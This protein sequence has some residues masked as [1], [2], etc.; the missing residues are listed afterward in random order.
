MTSIFIPN[1][2]HRPE[3]TET[4]EVNRHL[5]NLDSLTPVQGAVRISHRGTVLEVQAKAETI[6]TLTCDRCLQQ[7]NH[8]LRV[9][10]QEYIWLEEPMPDML[11]DEEREVAM[12]E[13]VETLS[14]QGHFDLE[15]WL[16][17]QLCL[18]LPMRNLCD[19]DCQGIQV[20][21]DPLPKPAAPTDHRWASL[22][23]LRNQLPN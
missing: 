23:A 20:N 13:L 5:P 3:Q 14:P 1:L 6:V 15:S 7:F 4:V 18:E 21:S 12:D 19:A 17:E 9:N 2:L 8:R 10:C 22:E 16:Y 11:D